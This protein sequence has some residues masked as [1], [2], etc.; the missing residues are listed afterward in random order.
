MST[1]FKSGLAAPALRAGLSLS[2]AAVATF[3][4]V[5]GSAAPVHAASPAAG[6]PTA[7]VETAGIDLT[8]AAGRAR[9]EAHVRR[10]ARSVCGGNESRAWRQV[11]AVRA[12]IE[13]AV[14]NSQPRL[15]A[16]AAAARDARTDLAD[17]APPATTG[18]P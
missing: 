11:P 7:R 15:E 10:A 17:I 3:V 8:S 1:T 14:A 12:C 6:F 9:V 2:I 13:T 5:A 4:I 16:L 18:R